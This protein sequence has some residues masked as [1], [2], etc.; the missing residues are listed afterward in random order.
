MRSRTIL[1]ASLC[2][3]LAACGLCVPAPRTLA[4]PRI[5]IVGSGSNVPINLY[6]AWTEEFNKK[7][8]GI[9]VRYLSMSTVEGIRQITE[10]SGDFAAGEIP[11]TD[12]QMHGAKV[13]LAQIPT[14]LVA[15]VPVYKLPGNPV[16]HF[17]GELLAEIFLGNV[18]AWNDPRIERL[19]A[20]VTLP[21]LPIKVVHRTAGKGSNY[22]FTDFLSK[23][24]SEWRTK[25]GKTPSP[26][27]PVGDDANRGEDMVEK[28]SGNSGTIGYVELNFARRVDIGYGDVRNAAG[29]FIR[30]APETIVA[31][32]NAEAKSVPADF[33]ASLTNAP[34]KDSYPLSSFTWI[35]AP[36]T[37]LAAERAQ[38]LKQFLSW[39]LEDGQNVARGLG[40]ATLPP[41]FAARARKMVNSIP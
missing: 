22:I 27:W 32:C 24:S 14:V 31:A 28:V 30:A 17:S 5:A 15:I 11:L 26:K 40:Y 6:T 23:T 37:G 2:V 41:E 36:V 3:V 33:R 19:N 34:G 13:S 35:Y 8:S 16:L 9:T 12:E 20:G 25:V 38:A 29:N 10:G 18:K 4:Q 1:R 7:N 21:A 39:G